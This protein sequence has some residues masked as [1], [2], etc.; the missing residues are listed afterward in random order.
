MRWTIGMPSYNNYLEVFFTVQ[1]LRMYHNLRD[2]EIIVIDNY[3]DNALQNFIRK[4]GS[5]TVKYY[6]H[7]EIQ[8]VSYAK[9]K[10]FEH[11]QGENVLVIDSHI[12]LKPGTLDIKIENDDLY[13]GVLMHSCQTKY[14]C[15]WVEQWRKEMWGIWAKTVTELPKEPFEIWAMG[16]GFFACRR[17]SWLGFNDAFRG[18]GGET[19]Y[20]QEKYRKAGRKVWCN[21]K[22]VWLHM[23]YG[24]GRKV[25]YNLQLNDR[26]RN[27]I[28]GFRELGMD[29]EPI[30]KEF[31]EQRFNIVNQST[32]KGS[33]K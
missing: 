5:G 3:G 11:A 8:G 6:K 12:L 2:C 18:F 23:F 16:A 4:H 10:I 1:A 30:K 24:D 15:E 22:M 14:S 7:N 19:G 26:I 28:I 33:Y 20:I 13:Q 32:L 9:N 31:G 27:Y 21:P 29:L 17:D 25:P